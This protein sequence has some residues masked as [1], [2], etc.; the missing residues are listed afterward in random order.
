MGNTG[1]PCALQPFTIPYRGGMERMRILPDPPFESMA[2]KADGAQV[3]TEVPPAFPF[4]SNG[5]AQPG[6]C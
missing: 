5:K 3:T 6:V 4:G 1:M 2:E